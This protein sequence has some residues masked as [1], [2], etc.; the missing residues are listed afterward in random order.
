M[1]HYIFGTSDTPEAAHRTNYIIAY[2]V[3]MAIA[4][5][6]FVYRT[7]AFFALCLRASTNLH[8]RV[9]RGISRATML[10]YNTNPTGR[11]LNRFAS[12]ISNIDTRLP[13]ALTDSISAILESLA[14]MSIVVTVNIWLVIPTICLILLIGTMRQ[15]Y[16]KTARSVKRIESICK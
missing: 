16:I 10:F 13:P 12:D 1:L 15:L 11:I 3:M 9:F 5:I 4:T 14:I 6:V 7:F 8:D 2:S